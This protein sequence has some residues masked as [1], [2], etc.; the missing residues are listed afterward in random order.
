MSTDLPTPG[1][2]R[3]AVPPD[4]SSVRETDELG[5]DED[6]PTEPGIGEDHDEDEPAPWPS[7]TPAESVPMTFRDADG[8][9]HLTADMHSSDQRRAGETPAAPIG[10]A[11]G[12]LRA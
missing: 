7:S 11:L 10:T 5:D 3:P 4:D 2:P 1:P 12:L 6:L 9:V 8:Q